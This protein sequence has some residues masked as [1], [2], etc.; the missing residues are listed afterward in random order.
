MDFCVNFEL[1]NILLLKLTLPSP[2]ESNLVAGH[3][4]E[5]SPPK[6]WED[7][8]HIQTERYLSK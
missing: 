6:S 2:M 7:A 8:I 4:L 1:L 3:S 5:K